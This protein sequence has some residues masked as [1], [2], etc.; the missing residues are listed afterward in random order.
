VRL[1][2]VEK[3]YDIGMP[4][5]YYKAFADFALRDPEHGDDFRVYLRDKLA[6]K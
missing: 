4:L 1:N 5:T 3:R 2:G 6:G